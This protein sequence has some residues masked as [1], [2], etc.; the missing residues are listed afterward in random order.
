M[1]IIRIIFYPIFFIFI[2]WVIF[3]SNVFQENRDKFLKVFSSKEQEIHR[4]YMPEE[5]SDNP[6]DREPLPKIN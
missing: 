4:Q 5:L 3:F 2:I 6:D 1:F